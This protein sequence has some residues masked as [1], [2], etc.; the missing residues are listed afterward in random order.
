MWRSWVDR[1]NATNKESEQSSD[2]DVPAVSPEVLQRRE[3]EHN[4]LRQLLSQALDP[5]IDEKES[6]D[7][8][9]QEFLPKFC[10]I[11]EAHKE[12]HV[13][14]AIDD[15]RSF[16]A[17]LTRSLLGGIRRVPEQ[18]SKGESSQVLMDNLRSRSHMYN[19]IRT[20]R[21]VAHG[22]DTLVDLML[23]Q[24]IPS[25]IIK[26][27]RSFIDLPPEYY[28]SNA[29]PDEAISSS[30]SNEDSDG[31]NV[32]DDDDDSDMVYFDEAGIVVTDTLKRFAQN[33][34][35]VR[36]LI[37]EDT[38][39]MMVRLISVKP[40]D[41]PQLSSSSDDVYNDDT[42]SSSSS[43]ATSSS[44]SAVEPAYMI[45]KRRA[46][47]VLKLVPMT[48]EVSQ[49]LKSRRCLDMM[50]Q[51]WND[52]I[53][54]GKLGLIDMREDLIALDL[55]T[56]Q[57]K[58]S[59]EADYHVL[60]DDFNHGKAWDT[61][62]SVVLA[63]PANSKVAELKI[64]LIDAI[65]RLTYIGKDRSSPTLSEGLPYQHPDFIFPKPDKDTDKNVSNTHAF[66][67]LL[68]AFTY[69]HTPQRLTA[70]AGLNRT[71]L[72][73]D[74]R[75]KLFM[76][77]KQ[78]IQM[79]AVNYFTL[80]RTNVLPLLIES[81]E[82]YDTDIQNGIMDVL[83][84]VIK[85]LNFVPL[86]E[87]AVLSLHFQ[88]S[89]TGNLVGL[90]CQRFAGLLRDFQKFRVVVRE[91][92][93]LNVL[94]LMLTDLTDG[95]NDDAEEGEEQHGQQTK[96]RENKGFV[97]RVSQDFD[98]IAG[99]LVEIFKDPSNFVFFQK[100]Y[101]GNLFDLLRYTQT[102]KGILR[103]IEC[104]PTTAVIADNSITSPTS[105][106]AAGS[107]VLPTMDIE[108]SFSKLI[109]AVQSIPRDD[110]DFRRQML[111]AMNR[112]FTAHPATR[113]IFR[114]SGG[115]VTLISMI[116]ALE[117]A[118]LD[119]ANYCVDATTDQLLNIL[120][121][122]FH[123]L[124]TSMRN[125]DI[126]KQ[127]FKSQVGYAA[128][129]NA[130]ELTGAL[131][132]N[133]V[134]RH[135]FGIL[136]AF[137]V[138]HDGHMNELF[139]LKKENS[140]NNNQ[141]E[142]QQELAHQVERVLKQTSVSVA[143]PEI[144]TTILNLQKS[145]SFDPELSGAIL[146]GIYS[147]ARCSRRN[148]VK[149][150]RCGVILAALNR[151]LPLDEEQHQQDS[152]RLQH[153]NQILLQVIKKLMTMGISYEEMRH[154][155]RGFGARGS[156]DNMHKD[157]GKHLMNLILDGAS[158]SRWPNFIQF[159]M[160]SS[161]YACLE[162]PS[163]PNFPP[164]TPGYTLMA[165]FHI[166]RM[167]EHVPLTLLTLLDSD[168]NAVSRLLIDPTTRRLQIHQVHVKQTVELTAFEFQPGY[169]YHI[170]IVHQ[171]A[172][173]GL[174]LS[175]ITLFVNGAWV[176]QARISY[177]SH[178]PGSLRAIIGTPRDHRQM[179]TLI[180]D[181]GPIYLVDETLE[182]DVLILYFNLGAR[183]K[184]M[185]QDALRQFQTYEAST[186]LFLSLRA[187]TKA[188]SRRD[189]DQSLLANV[190]RGAGSASVQESKFVFAYIACNTLMEGP[191]TGLTCTGL[192]NAAQQLIAA[193]NKQAQLVL[194]AAIP[195]VE[196]ALTSPRA[197]GYL[198]GNPVVAY[199][200]GVDESL[201][202][203]GGSAVALTLVERSETSEMLFKAVKVL[204]ETIRYSWRNSEDM[205]RCHG[206]E[207][208]A[209]VLKQKRELITVDMMEE[210]LMFIGKDPLHPEES[211]INNP[212]AYRYVI[213]NF[214]VWKKTSV[215]V[216][217]A[218]LDQF[219]LFLRSSKRRHF[220]LKRLQKFHLVKRML[221]AFR[222]H[223]YSK[224]LTPEVVTAL[225]TVTLCSWNTE[226]IR[227]IA[228]FLASTVSKDVANG[229]ERNGH[230]QQRKFSNI[231]T[232]FTNGNGKENPDIGVT[233]ALITDAKTCNN[234]HTS[235][236]VQM[237]NVVLEMLHDILCGPNE[238][239]D[240]VTKFAATI[241]NRW[242]LLFFGPD[243]HPF[244]VVLVA[245][246]LA[247]ILVTQGP[248][249]VTKFRTSSEGFL[250]L[251]RLLPRYWSLTQLHE[252]LIV[253]MMGIDI[254]QFPM[255]STFDIQHIRA[256][257][258]Q[259]QQQ[260]SAILIPD[261]MPIIVALWRQGLH[262]AVQPLL[263]D[264]QDDETAK[265]TSKVQ[266]EFVQF[267]EELYKARSDFRDICCKSDVID[268]MSG[269]LFPSVTQS[270]MTSVADELTMAD[271]STPISPSSVGSTPRILT[272][273]IDPYFPDEPQ[274]IVDSAPSI[275]RRGGSSAIATKTSPHST[276]R[277]GAMIT[278]LR[279]GSSDSTGSPN[280]MA[281]LKDDTL[282]TLL[283]FV[284]NISVQAIT[285]PLNK[286]MTGLLLVLTACPPTTE[287]A[288]TRYESFLM[289]HIAQS[290]KSTL[291][292]DENLLGDGRVV[293]NV[294]R[295]CQMAA[296]AVL[297]G[298][299]TNGAEQ[300]Y[301]LLASVIE[302]LHTSDFFARHKTSSQTINELYRSFNRMILLKISDLEQGNM[303]AD[304]IIAFLNYCIHHQK[305]ILST[306]NTD[307]NFL[308]CF[309]YH[310][311]QFLLVDDD[312]VKNDAAN[313][314]KLLVLQKPD[315]LDSLF[316]IRAKGVESDEV[317]SGFKQ[318]LEMDTNSFFVWIESRTHE[319]NHLFKE[320]MFKTWENIVLHENR[321]AQEMLK[322]QQ[323]RR[324][325]KL[326]KLQ[327]RE[328]HEDQ[329]LRDY[330]VKTATWSESIQEVEMSRF[331]KALQDNDGHDNFIQSEWARLAADLFRERGLWGPEPKDNKASKWRLDYTE[332][333][334][335]MRKKIQRIADTHPQQYK[336]K[337][338]TTSTASKR[339][340]ASCAP[341]ASNEMAAVGPDND[342]K[343]LIDL[344]EDDM[345]GSPQVGR[346]EQKEQR[347]TVP[348]QDVED[349][350][351]EQ[352]EKIAYEEDKNRKV[353]RLLDYG[354][355]V[356][357][358]Y[359]VS[360]IAG[361]DA[362][363]GLL[364][365]CKQN[366][367]LVDNFFQ[368][369]DGEVVEIWDVPKEER[370]QYLILLAQAAGM[371]TESTTDMSG[372]LHACR[373]WSNVDIKEVY[374]RRFLFRDVALE[375]FFGD[376]RNALIT[377]A[378][379]ERD[380]LYSKLA[381]RVS[382]YE[383]PSDSILGTSAEMEMASGSFK[384]SNLFGSST[385]TDLTAKW[386]RREI[387]N[388]QYLMYLNAIAG[389]SYNDLTQYPV[390]PWILAD[391]ESSE[392]DL[393]NPSSFRDLTKPMGAQTRERRVEFAD[394]Y[395][396]WG[397]TNNPDPAFH[398]GTHYSSAMIV[399]SF[400]IRLEPFTQHYLNLQGGTFDHADRLFDSVGKAWESASEKNMG[401]V[402]ELIPEFFYLPE[403]LE[404]VNKFDFGAKQG[405]GETIDSV[406]LPP[407]ANGDPKIFVQRH[408]E[409]LESDYVSENLCHW[410]DLIFGHKQQGQA[411]IDALNVFHHVSYEGAV[412]LDSITNVVEKTATIGIINNFG[413]TPRQ[414]FKKPHP[415]RQPANSHSIMDRIQV[416]S[417]SMIQS[418][419]PIRD[420]KRQVAEIGVFNERLGVT[421][422]QQRFVPSDGTRYIEWGFSDNSLRLLSTD[423]GKLLR[424]FENMHMGYVSTACFPD[425]RILATGSTD[426]TVC[427][428]KVKH[429]KAMDFTLLEC[430]RGHSSSVV[431]LA[432]SRS[433]SVLVSG[434]NDKTAIIWDLN[435]MEYVRTLQGH[436]GPVD[437]VQVNDS[438]GDIITCSGHTLRV[439]TINGDLYLTKSAC[440]SSEAI[441]SAV[442][443]EG[444]LNEWCKNDFLVT[445]HRRGIIKFWS[446]EL[447]KDKNG[448]AQ[449]G[450][451]LKRQI[452]HHDHSNGEPDIT[453]LA[454]AG[455]SKRTLLTGNSYGEVYTFVAPD[456]TDTLH[457]V[458]DDRHKDCMLCRRAFS[459]LERK[460]NCRTCG[461]VICSNCI[462]NHHQFSHDRLVRI[463]K[464]CS[465]KLPNT[466]PTTT[467]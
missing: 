13:F 277:L 304:Q 81:M 43:P 407:W 119:P 352:E 379:E 196:A 337:H 351:L 139:V 206:Y 198:D 310:L 236:A 439:W 339:A 391:Y 193:S 396:Q 288:Q 134:P 221:L 231:V 45:W 219:T 171:R 361:L 421:S 340:S 336:P 42:T 56:Y 462:V 279:T 41:W 6:S 207:I 338:T 61:L 362:R 381:S 372:D 241:T 232:N 373:K 37:A 169:W 249:Y 67:L 100:T 335:R 345:I 411:A 182:D 156:F 350:Q 365:L 203:I 311:Y 234:N 452:Q 138:D 346:P 384:L 299:F 280:S 276:R 388:F 178:P 267:F 57:L 9:L 63:T 125:N 80:E 257:V 303:A 447:V 419:V 154:I 293:S 238:H 253:A 225:K 369:R 79:S 466:T 131:A 394:R 40:A 392:L 144:T 260:Q 4:E 143:N 34:S 313:I 212:F 256:C 195:K 448:K 410:I 387:T 96:Q 170:G 403:F 149:L 399:C 58:A 290:L 111:L 90:I 128:L 271:G 270:V 425:S 360:Q 60:Y 74:I 201:W 141:Q 295:F 264:T 191:H 440:P 266:D 240:L 77:M 432:A 283:E 68:D 159:D 457:Y 54:K 243:L 455:S 12:D 177:P 453:A 306:R 49:Y 289:V 405:T 52:S 433:Y 437:T 305:I 344:E 103:V 430:L 401:D 162:V 465:E 326:R 112:I 47:D 431:S 262:T 334:Q 250:I 120:Q 330:T 99:C 153:E 163:I 318:M 444:T 382:L 102:R 359:N 50:I 7:L 390:F 329:L 150:N 458:R 248:G 459:V 59:L 435:R 168:S 20:I 8:F 91:A 449:W 281:V 26:L 320:H 443:Y 412:D 176:E 76:E 151:I 113:D 82:L 467:S 187:M 263:V 428:W 48:T 38:F 404:N 298:R 215:D 84:Y 211:L 69:P 456:S 446:K 29:V 273:N 94:S 33:R 259:Q 417:Q 418:I 11:W 371:E 278:K 158:R 402:R 32:D 123:V 204:C 181:L 95:L 275:I 297:Q 2:V 223:I 214:E 51:A 115:Y 355:M 70:A 356:L 93:I 368:R 17:K 62:T 400:L 142:H 370:D 161:G 319:L 186:T 286:I 85:D 98:D 44:S 209:Y 358:V 294:A 5:R 137:A 118:F 242:P 152:N 224:E 180:W 332:G 160:S 190:M 24:R 175:S 316:K 129:E 254:S 71:Q 185:F 78:I 183:Y 441:L 261:L 104:F 166:E 348:E 205:E 420:I 349:Q 230:H 296:D 380:E 451:V 21:V 347:A 287:D 172:R 302:S 217:K 18:K 247:R 321:Y 19:I 75:R 343:P 406:L 216:Q 36:R 66:Q 108:T 147:L 109:E 364:L 317:I 124:A 268:C 328:V 374:K 121:A 136:F 114:Q 424:V 145:I 353:L 434:S 265:Y 148:Q 199:P 300:T 325:A 15:A 16:I 10:A 213:L 398:Y 464:S 184:S 130:L 155:F 174:N 282:Q 39:F 194:N 309:C 55:A 252:T 179:S 106:S 146:S 135:V 274:E 202:R 414:L 366:I 376:G 226:S 429:E 208:L 88:S 22:P 333:R 239:K 35:V 251:S 237:R 87:L 375:I 386:E 73:K 342:T 315:V 97:Q 235:K 322:D 385:L 308:K 101:R 1:I 133:G 292:F 89:S 327:K 307:I 132:S 461:A 284:V 442:Y 255:H 460:Y 188:F 157:V 454:F 408:R 210:L 357:D 65:V 233:P 192:S 117:G 228:T 415:A 165:W 30:A 244:S 389:R 245:R 200:Y 31:D 3:Q 83:V 25:V 218:H 92:G 197:M 86:K 363:E 285:D 445:G 463:C 189:M 107:S 46:L 269:I 126:N 416:N 164:S 395:K 354:D 314:W 116:V 28:N 409:A 413:Q 23:Q 378:K 140:D 167:D 53:T 127:F 397:E 301:D 436:D 427:M 220:N 450:L 64:E 246:I 341:K 324:I 312:L 422:C 27:F 227:A 258:L 331:T 222:M 110:L 72:P 438:T 323:I 423:S 367:Y 272:N 291:Q 377:V 173:L 229:G 383:R 426:G 14:A 122:I 393:T 105:P